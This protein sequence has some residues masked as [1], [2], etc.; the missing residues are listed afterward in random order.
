[1][2]SNID[3]R[4][5]LSRAKAPFLTQNPAVIPF[6]NSWKARSRLVRYFPN[7]HG[8]EC[9]RRP[10]VITTQS[11]CEQI[12]ALETKHNP[13]KEM[14]WFKQPHGK[15]KIQL[16]LKSVLHYSQLIAQSLPCSLPKN[17]ILND[18]FS[19]DFNVPSS[20]LFPNGM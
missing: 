1:M 15:Y 19:L 8:E 3:E 5:T 9:P 16:N 18:N 20:R 13:S 14:L 10:P 11:K 6:V 4:I 12:Q 2:F 7:I 17:L